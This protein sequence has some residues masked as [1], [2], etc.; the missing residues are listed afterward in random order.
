MKLTALNLEPE[1]NCYKI[2]SIN[3]QTKCLEVITKI[4]KEKND[5]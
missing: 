5:P 3:E 4:D 1:P 2:L